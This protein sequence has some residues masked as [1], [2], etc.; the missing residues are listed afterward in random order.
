MPW[1]R[2]YSTHTL[3]LFRLSCLMVTTLFGCPCR[4]GNSFMWQIRIKCTRY[5]CQYRQPVDNPARIAIQYLR[6]RLTVQ[7]HPGPR[8]SHSLIK[9]LHLL[10]PVLPE[11]PPF[12]S[13]L[14]V[15]GERE[16][17]NGRMSPLR[18]NGTPLRIRRL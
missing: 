9:R 5:L 11:N 16:Q 10:I 12:R 1:S 3:S 6:N 7:R 8:T 14:N 17:P 2:Q 13:H 15:P 18:Q 4:K